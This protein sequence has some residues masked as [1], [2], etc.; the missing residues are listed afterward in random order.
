MRAKLIRKLPAGIDAW[1]RKKPYY[2]DKYEF[3]CVDCGEHYYSGH[4]DSRTVPWCGEC[5]RKHTKERQK[6]YKARKEREIVN[7]ALKGMIEELEHIEELVITAK[8]EIE[9]QSSKV[10]SPTLDKAIDYTFA[11]I[12]RC[13][14]ERGSN[15]RDMRN[16]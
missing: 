6:E 13:E 9:R 2:F 7:K 8:H 14:E 5:Y 12:R 11:L 10:Y 4:C 16:V 15:E 3:E 1:G